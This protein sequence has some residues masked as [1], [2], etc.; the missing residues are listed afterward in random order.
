MKLERLHLRN[1][2]CFEDITVDF[3]KRLTVIIADNGAGKTALLDAIAIGFGRYLTKLPSI[4]GRTTRKTDLRVGVKERCEPFLWIAWEARTHDDQLLTWSSRRRRDASVTTAFIEKQL[5]VEQLG[6]ERGQKE[7]DGFSLGL[8]EAE[9]NQR[10]YFLPV[11]TYY[12]TNRTI[13]EEVQRRR[14]FKKNFTRFDALAEAL[15]PDSRFR[16]AFEWFNA[17]EDVQRREREAQRDFDYQHPDLQIVREA[18]ER[19]LQGYKNPRTEIRPLRFVI[20]HVSPSGQVRTLRVSQL[21]DGY[22]VVLGV[23]MDLARRMMEANNH[24][25]PVSMQERNPLDMPAIVLI[26]E[27]DLHLHPRWQ[28][29]IVTDLMQTFTNTQ[30]IVT[31]HSPQ[32][33]STVKRENVR[34]ICTDSAGHIVVRQ[35]LAATYGEPSGDV[36]HSVMLVDPQP[37]I[38]EKKDLQQLTEWIDQGRYHEQQ[39]IKLMQELTEALG[40]QHPQLQRL[41][42]SI[43][44]Q[45][46]LKQ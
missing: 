39:V 10:P 40:E 1:F 26:D 38:T 6:L 36:M 15:E 29:R 35:P 14:G 16:A 43:Q 4:S 45:E 12:G 22:R 30:F 3:G 9:A 11:V 33:L 23:V 34:V 31:T 5:S 25:V 27:L 41:K 24:A 13:R 46:A 18:I 8:V 2:R 7:I 42:R 20:D 28:Q 32:V 19:L 17:M 21:S 44:R 37:P